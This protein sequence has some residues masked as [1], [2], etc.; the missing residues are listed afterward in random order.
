VADELHRQSLLGFVA[1]E[2]DAKLHTLVVRLK[3]ASM[4]PRAWRSYQAPR[5]HN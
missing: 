1:P 2:A 3:D 4:R 5:P